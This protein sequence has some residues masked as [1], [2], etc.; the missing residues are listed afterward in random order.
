MPKLKSI[1]IISLILFGICV[2]IFFTFSMNTAQIATLNDI[3]YKS[4]NGKMTTEDKELLKE[5]DQILTL[6]MQIL[7]KESKNL[8][9][10]VNEESLQLFNTLIKK[11][12]ICYGEI[13]RKVFPEVAENFIEDEYLELLDYT[14]I[15]SKE[16]GD[17]TDKTLTVFRKV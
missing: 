8:Q 15:N 6:S 14:P 7:G 2:T 3:V 16:K 5:M 10:E 11:E 12:D 9:A 4:D 1:T 17:V 13:L